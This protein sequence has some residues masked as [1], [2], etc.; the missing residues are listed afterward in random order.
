M[1]SLFVLSLL[2]LSFACRKEEGI[3]DQL[4]TDEQNAIRLRAYN[5]CMSKSQDHFDN[6]KTVSNGKFYGVDA[7]DAG[8]TF[9][10]TIKD[11]DTVD[12]THKITVWQSDST[13]VYFLIHEDEGAS[14]SYKFVKVPKVDN[15]TMIDTIQDAGCDKTITLSTSGRTFKPSVIETSIRRTTDT[16]T[17]SESLLAFMSKYKLARK[18]ETLDDG[19]VTATKNYTGTLTGPADEAGIPAYN[20]Y[21][22]YVSAGITPSLCTVTTSTPPFSIDCNTTFPSSEL[23]TLP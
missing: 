22:A 11:G 17:Y 15:E 7:Y 4:S 2:L 23:N 19:N 6:F 3:W 20:S 1:K 16:Y 10:H 5:S 18:V 12:A 14:D 13:N 9:T 21:A 8:L